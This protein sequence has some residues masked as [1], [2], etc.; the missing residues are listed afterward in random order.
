MDADAKKVF[1]SL[2]DDLDILGWSSPSE[3]S[4]ECAANSALSLIQKTAYLRRK[5]RRQAASTKFHEAGIWASNASSCRYCLKGNSSLNGSS[6]L[7]SSGHLFVPSGASGLG[8]RG[9]ESSPTRKSDLLDH[10]SIWEKKPSAE[11]RSEYDHEALADELIYDLLSRQ[12]PSNSTT[13][14]IPP[15]LAPWAAAS[16]WAMGQAEQNLPLM[17]FSLE[18][19]AAWRKKPSLL[20]ARRAIHA[21]ANSKAANQARLARPS[22]VYPAEGRCGSILAPLLQAELEMLTAAGHFPKRLSCGPQDIG[23]AWLGQMS[24]AIGLTSVWE[25]VQRISASKHKSMSRAFRIV[26]AWAALK[27]FYLMCLLGGFV[28]EVCRH[29]HSRIRTCVAPKHAESNE[30]RAWRKGFWAWASMT[31]STTMIASLSQRPQCGAAQEEV[32]SA[33]FPDDAADSC[34][35]IFRELW[36]REVKERGLSGAS[37][38]RVL[39]Q[40][41]GWKKVL[42]LL[43]FN[44]VLGAMKRIVAL[45]SV[46]MFLGTLT[47]IS[48]VQNSHPDKELDLAL[49][50]TMAIVTYSALP[51]LTLI[52]DCTKN[53]IDS[54]LDLRVEAALGMMVYSKSQRLPAVKTCSDLQGFPDIVQLVTVDLKFNM[55]LFTCSMIFLITQPVSVIFM[56]AFLCKHLRWA[57]PL[58]LLGMLPFL[59]FTMYFGGLIKRTG[60]QY[61]A[62]VDRRVCLLSEVF[63]NMRIVKSYG[64]EEAHE[65]KLLKVRQEE[66]SQLGWLL[67]AIV[68]LITSL[69]TAPNL[70]KISCLGAYVWLYGSIDAHRIFICMQILAVLMATLTK[71]T[72]AAPQCITALTS[73]QRVECYLK[74][75]EL[76]NRDRCQL[77]SSPASAKQTPADC[78]LA[79]HVRGTFQVQAEFTPVLYDFKLDIRQGAFVA[80]V[81]EVGCGK[82]LLLQAIL[83]E[84]HPMDSAS[85]ETASREVA[86]CAEVPWIVNGS[87]RENVLLGHR[88]PFDEGRYSAVLAAA[89]LGPDIAVLPGGDAVPIGDRGITLS[90]GQKMRVALARAAYGRAELILMDSPFAAVDACTRQVL[91]DQLCKGPLMQNRTRIAVVQ[92]DPE[93]LMA[94]D[95]VIVLVKGRVAMQGAPAQVVQS[96]AFKGLLSSSQKAG[97]ERVQKTG[98]KEE[99][100]LSGKKQRSPGELIDEESRGEMDWKTVEFWA[101]IG[102][103]RLLVLSLSF[104]FLASGFQLLGDVQIANWANDN[105]LGKQ[106]AASDSVYIICCIFWLLSNAFVVTLGFG[107]G[108]AYSLDVSHAIHAQ[109]LKSTMQ[110]PLR[111]FDKTPLGHIIARFLADL[112]NIDRQLYFKIAAVCCFLM[113]IVVILCYCHGV[114]PL[115]FS[116]LA[117]PFYGL[118]LWMARHYYNCVFQLMYLDRALISEVSCHLT[119]ASHSSIFVRAMGQTEFFRSKFAQTLDRQL[120]AQFLS[121]TVVSNWFQMRAASTFFFL[122]TLVALIGIAHANYFGPGTV[123]L[124]LTTFSLVVEMFPNWLQESTY[125][126]FEMISMVRLH[127]YTKLP[128]ETPAVMPEDHKMSSRWVTIPREV[129]QHVKVL[130]PR[131]G[132]PL[133]AVSGDGTVL[134]QA[135]ADGCSL[136]PSP[137]GL[138]AAARGSGDALLA[139]SRAHRISSVN[140][141]SGDA[142]A[143]MAELCGGGPGASTLIRLYLENNWMRKGASVQIEKLSAGYGQSPDVLRGISLEIQARQRVGIVGSTGAGKS[144]LMLVMLRLLE[145]RSGR[146]LINGK[147]T[148][149]LGLRT[150]RQAI[151]F[152]PQDPVLFSGSLRE[153]LDPFGWYTDEQVWLSL[154]HTRVADF[155]EKLPRQ[156]EQTLEGGGENLSFGQRQLLCLARMVLRQPKLLLFDEATSALDPRTQEIVMAALHSV[157][158]DC[159]VV[160]VAHRLETVLDC[161][162]VVVME[163]GRIIEKGGPAALRSMTEG[164]F[165]KMLMAGHTGVA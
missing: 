32:S 15:L 129:L 76:P 102:R 56:I 131:G 29:W 55:R 104:L 61:Q 138:A 72:A 53:L 24:T 144:S 162:V 91:L 46:D 130:L 164:V 21:S 43:T 26:M 87:L 133:Q 51:V 71:A 148:A 2:P 157:F 84:L 10:E 126:Q 94:F 125:A 13:S 163:N 136:E 9:V 112:G 42:T 64:W 101:A 23:E 60:F 127:E 140:Y 82:S 52:M 6:L 67:A 54:R 142:A 141:K 107:I 100:C 150:L 97:G 152:V 40:Y 128:Q 123:A 122:Q 109:V 70:L 44:M 33:G 8:P 18:P 105:G 139:V 81:G 93:Q 135:A 39:F 3:T 124:C 77:S 28:M 120:R 69:H 17:N 146:I 155:V 65:E 31:W 25:S 156:L 48:D 20:A 99:R 90:G 161:D 11:K 153:N 19:A 68:G 80:I 83:G 89:S 22:A 85:V 95:E 111:F 119:E 110:A 58:G 34:Y 75:D 149:L 79:V 113:Q 74:Q 137:A 47:W 154:T 14:S 63:G 49:P 27:T 4:N 45:L 5:V 7:F 38:K 88:E 86:Y 12:G 16:Y 158:V 103:T 165:Y 66:L 50:S 159:T 108:V 96:E 145:P 106:Q 143:M 117:L 160:A 115:I 118:I 57:A 73:L 134:F 41:I 132:N 36:E 116:L 30:L 78:P 37:L 1:I 147:D 59:F 151:G 98:A 114:M 121:N 62:H 92:P 35:N